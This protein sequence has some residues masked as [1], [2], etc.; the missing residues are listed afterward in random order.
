MA[1]RLKKKG[2]RKKMKDTLFNTII[3]NANALWVQGSVPAW[4]RA[5]WGLN[6]AD[7]LTFYVRIRRDLYT[8]NF[9]ELTIDLN[10]KPFICC[11]DAPLFNE[12]KQ[13]LKAL[14]YQYLAEL[15]K[16]LAT[17][18]EASAEEVRKAQNG[19]RALGYALLH[20]LGAKIQ[21]YKI[22]S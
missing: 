18:E 16:H 11:L 14:G 15:A 4:V 13:Y 3:T 8:F 5:Y 7:K 6:N 12:L 22:F 1:N 20:A 19:M 21:G 17:P 2:Y 10:N 9:D